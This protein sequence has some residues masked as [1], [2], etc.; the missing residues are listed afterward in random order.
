MQGREICSLKIRVSVVRLMELQLRCLACSV[1]RPALPVSVQIDLL[2]ILTP[3]GRTLCVLIR[4]ANR[5]A[6]S[7][8]LQV[9]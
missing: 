2:S 1:C 5:S 9:F 8:H 6:P 3:A 4:F 7:H